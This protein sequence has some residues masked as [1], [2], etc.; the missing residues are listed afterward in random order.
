LAPEPCYLQGACRCLP[1]P[2]KYGQDQ[3]SIGQ[4]AA[5]RDATTLQHASDSFRSAS[6][7]NFE[8]QQNKCTLANYLETWDKMADSAG[9]E[10]TTSAFGGHRA[11]RLVLRRAP[12]V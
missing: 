6:A 7:A 11:R 8:R 12:A 3:P 10:L 2:M 4:S 5:F 1:P 9:L